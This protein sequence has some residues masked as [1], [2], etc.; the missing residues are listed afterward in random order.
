MSLATGL[1]G[2]QRFPEK[3]IYSASGQE[4]QFVLIERDV[5]VYVY[6]M[7]VKNVGDFIKKI[8]DVATFKGF[9]QVVHRLKKISDLKGL[10]LRR[11][12]ALSYS[13][14]P[15]RYSY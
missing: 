1:S 11:D 15:R 10:L 13:A 4:F 8:H 5:Y 14:H 6:G 12:L 7:E 3:F 2:I 9:E